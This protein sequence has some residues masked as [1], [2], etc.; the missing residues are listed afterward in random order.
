MIFNVV[1]KWKLTDELYPH[2]NVLYLQMNYTHT[3]TFSIYRWIIPAHERS[4]STDELY[5]HMNVLYLQMNYTRTWT[6][7]IC[8]WIIPAH[9]RSLYTDELYPH[10]NV[11]YLQMNY[12]RIWTFSIYIM[13]YTRTWTFSI[14]RWIIPA[15]ERSLSADELYPH[16]NVL[17][18]QMNYTRTWTFSIYIMN[19]TRTWTFSICRWII[20][21]H[22]RSLSTDELYPH[23]NV[24]VRV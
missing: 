10:M 11:L 1:N 17:F 22:E 12:T 9:E 16:M 13:N 15:Y 4:I 18:L 7:S 19:Y 23:M 14:Y 6:F 2:M 21:A 20:P 5:P 24:H 3:W 8:R